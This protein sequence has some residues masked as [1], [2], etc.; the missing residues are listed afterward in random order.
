MKVD[1]RA[2]DAWIDQEWPLSD[3]SPRPPWT[4]DV[5]RQMYIDRHHALAAERAK[6]MET[7][8]VAVLRREN[9]ALKLRV[10]KIER[11][12]MSKNGGLMQALGS[13][14]GDLRIDLEKKL[15][16]QERRIPKYRGYWEAGEMYSKSSLV[17]HGGSLWMAVE[18]TEERPG[19]SEAWALCAKRG[20]DQRKDAT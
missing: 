1:E 7:T 4:R 14:I 8:E 15:A 11:F 9:A 19:S 5:W 13:V 6:R 20:R 18:P 16:E 12:A 2:L 10:A 17:T 3:N